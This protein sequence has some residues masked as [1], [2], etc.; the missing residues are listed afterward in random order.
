MYLPGKLSF[1]IP[2]IHSTSCTLLHTLYQ[3]SH[4][5]PPSHIL[6]EA[7]PGTEEDH[8]CIAY[9]T[10]FFDPY[11]AMYVWVRWDYQ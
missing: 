8:P 7:V 10:Y 11:R 3:T 2:V 1:I 6:A 9:G 4:I 5:C